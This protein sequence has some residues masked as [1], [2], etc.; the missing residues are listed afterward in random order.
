MNRRLTQ[1]AVAI[2][3]LAQLPASRAQHAPPAP[4][5]AWHSS[6]DSGVARQLAALPQAVWS[7]DLNKTYSLAELIDLAELHNPDTRASWERARIRAAELGIERAAYLPTIAAVVYTASLR[8]PSLSDEYF[9]RQTIALYQST[10]HVDYLILDFGGRAGDVDVAK[11]NLIAANLAFNDT[12]RRLIFDISAAYFRFLNAQGQREAAEVNLKNA[13][14]V[15]A[16]A[17]DRL[18]HGLATK[19]DMLEATAARA[20]ADFDLQAALGAEAIGLGRVVTLMGLPSETKLKVQG[21]SEISIP[22]AVTD[23]LSDEIAR[24][25]QQRPELLEAIAHIR[26]AK[27]AL[28]Q[29]QSS[30]FP[31]LHFAGDGGVAR[32]YGQEDLNPGHYAEGEVWT[33][34]LSLRWTLFDGTRRE[35]EV[36]AASAQRRSAEAELQ[37]LRDRIDEEVFT[38]YVDMQ[39]ALRQRQAA[40]ALLVASTQSYQAAREAYGFGLRNELDV[41]AAQKALAQARYE[42]VTARSQVLLQ[43]A[44]LAFRTGDM[45]Q[46]HS[47][48]T[49]Q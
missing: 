11:A 45:I 38:S 32:G 7:V 44:D 19:P 22:D 15:E 31:S 43:A 16:D 49:T 48:R 41:V 4:E 47:Q 29:A 10:L 28:K 35:H 37:A 34:G 42:D 21:L 14:T 33:A 20:Q 9:H 27:G 5:H 36:L 39:T 46:L 24:A 23:S 3:C 13:E 25:V 6:E 12:H 26:A 18:Q 1:C 40:A 30:Y 8:Q 2:A 17:Q